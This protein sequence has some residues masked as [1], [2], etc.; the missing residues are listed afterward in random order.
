MTLEELKA[1]MAP[2]GY[3]WHESHVVGRAGCFCLPV[4][5]ARPCSHNH[6]DNIT[7]QVADHG[8]KSKYWPREGR[9]TIEVDITGELSIGSPGGVWS[10]LLLYSLSP[11]E[12]LEH[13]VEVKAALIRAWE[14]LG[15][16]PISVKTPTLLDLY[17]L[18]ETLRDAIKK[19]S[20]NTPLPFQY[21]TAIRDVVGCVDRVRDSLDDLQM[22]LD[23]CKR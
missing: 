14:A 12:F 5:T 9:Y 1:E 10:K 17:V 22:V 20:E 19:F 21:S 3:S 8:S 4:I 2:L 23:R 16:D 15:D 13:H 6:R 18:T 11:E 7:V